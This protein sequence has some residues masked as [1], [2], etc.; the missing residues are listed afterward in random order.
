MWAH[1]TP[2]FCSTAAT[3]LE[4][5]YSYSTP[6]CTGINVMFAVQSSPLADRPVPCT[7]WDASKS[8]NSHDIAIADEE[9]AVF[10]L[11]AFLLP[12]AERS[13]DGTVVVAPHAKQQLTELWEQPA[14]QARKPLALDLVVRCR[15][16]LATS[17]LLLTQLH[18][19]W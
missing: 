7:I 9:R 19:I 11:P 10:S 2:A 8:A 5:T 3:D 12:A 4:A 1:V 15:L 14:G 16:P 6:C 17:M 13:D 18:W